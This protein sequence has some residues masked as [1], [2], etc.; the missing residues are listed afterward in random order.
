MDFGTTLK[1]L[2][3]KNKMTQLQLANLLGITKSVVSFYENRERTPSPETLVKIASVFHVT[4][5]YLLGIDRSRY[6][7]VSGLSDDD[8][9]VLIAMVNALQNKSK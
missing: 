6:I 8:V 4:T 1:E 5:D 2:R 7:D 3:K 9:Q